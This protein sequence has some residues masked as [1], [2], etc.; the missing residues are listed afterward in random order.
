MS[1]KYDELRG[2]L[3]RSVIM[4]RDFLMEE[5]YHDS[6]AA[7][8]AKEWGTTFV[9]VKGLTEAENPST[10][11][12]LELLNYTSLDYGIAIRDPATGKEVTFFAAHN[13]ASDHDYDSQTEEIIQYDPMNKSESGLDFLPK[14]HE[15]V[16][17]Y[18]AAGNL[19]LKDPVEVDGSYDLDAADVPSES[20]FKLDDPESFDLE[21]ELGEDIIEAEFSEI[22]QR[23]LDEFATKCENCLELE[24]LPDSMLCFA[25]TALGVE[26]SPLEDPER[27]EDYEPLELLAKV[28][29]HARQAEFQSRRLLRAGKLLI[30]KE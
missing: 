16:E 6:D 12:L 20:D 1:L 26:C 24:R 7:E 21:G 19:I 30:N 11:D 29:H 13:L 8:L 4:V 25:C 18:D 28:D 27:P 10:H 14:V 5:V 9:K 23:D 17:L 3:S 15:R 22:T 2:L